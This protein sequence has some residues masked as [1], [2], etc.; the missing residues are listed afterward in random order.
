[1]L[2][3]VLV[4]P[5]MLWQMPLQLLV[6]DLAVEGAYALVIADDMLLQGVRTVEALSTQMASKVSLFEM[7]LLVKTQVG[8]TGKSLIAVV[9][10]ELF[11]ARV[12]DYVLR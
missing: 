9:A 11:D 4:S 3:Y 8:S 2:L 7:G 6:A 12:S 5:F 10:F 1:M